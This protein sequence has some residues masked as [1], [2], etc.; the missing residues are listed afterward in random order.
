MNRSEAQQARRTR[1]TA[2]RL[3]MAATLREAGKRP[4]TASTD[5][6]SGTPIRRSPSV[7]VNKPPRRARTNETLAPAY[8]PEDWGV[9]D[10]VYEA[11]SVTGTHRGKVVG[12][13][14]VAGVIVR[15]A[16]AWS[17]NDLCPACNAKTQ[18]GYCT[19]CAWVCDNTARP[20]PEPIAWSPVP[21][22]VEPTPRVT[23][24]TV[25]ELPALPEL[26]I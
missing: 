24:P 6:Q 17:W 13:L 1:E 12:R 23:E 15:D 8:P 11:G 22:A 26:E 2:E 9:S 5:K 25:T 18:F 16:A 4:T 7:S 3:S 20:A 19:R 10:L 14:N 21:R